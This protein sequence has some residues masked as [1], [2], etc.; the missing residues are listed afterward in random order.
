MGVMLRK[1]TARYFSTKELACPCC[2]KLSVDE[3]LLERLDAVRERLG[4]PIEVGSCYRC[5]R[6]N[7]AKRGASR[8][9]HLLSGAVDID[10]L[11]RIPALDLAEIYCETFP[12]VGIYRTVGMDNGFFHVDLGYDDGAVWWTRDAYKGIDY[13]YI[14]S[15]REFI[16]LIA[17]NPVW[18]GLKA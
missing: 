13:K 1:S 4:V 12:R 11:G 3:A 16:D 17:A 10:T 8:S 15:A 2:G 5:P 14:Y 6:H 18:K 9:L 7:R